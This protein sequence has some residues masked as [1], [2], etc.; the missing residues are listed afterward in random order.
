MCVGLYVSSPL[1]TLADAVADTHV[2]VVFV[3]VH[4]HA[5]VAVCVQLAVDAR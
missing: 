3:C 5:R 1:L 2:C 4:V